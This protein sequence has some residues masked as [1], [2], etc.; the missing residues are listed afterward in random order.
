VFERFPN[1]KFVATELTTGAPVASYLSKLDAQCDPQSV[2]ARPFIKDAVERLKRLP[3]EYFASN[4]FLGGPLD[5][6]SAYASGTPNLMFGA[7]IPH[8]EGTA[9]YTLD[10]MRTWFSDLPNAEIRAMLG[11][12]AAE[13]YDLDMTQLQ[14]IADDV[15][16]RVDDL[17]TPAGDANTRYPEGAEWQPTS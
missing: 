13:V 17:S 16:P 4:C 6:P 15:G 3:S 12:R 2:E 5:L 10:T 1:L 7:D 9:P 11:A 14:R 8:S